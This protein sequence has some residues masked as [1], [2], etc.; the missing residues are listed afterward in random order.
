MSVFK[1][2]HAN[3]RY[4]E[5]VSPDTASKKD[6]IKAIQNKQ[7][8]EYI[9]R[10]TES[11]SMAYIHLPVDNIVKVIINKKRKEL[12]TILPWKDIYHT[13][14]NTCGFIID[15][16]PDCYLETN[17]LSTLNKVMAYNNDREEYENLSFNSLLFET[18]IH[19]AWL[20]HLG[21]EDWHN[22]EAKAS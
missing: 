7:N 4:F 15:L 2:N 5:R 19:K 13:S 11:R 21:L 3:Q 6:I 12:V 9:K 17:S 10:L 20:I 8:I 16:Y 1:N 14:I 22:E 18:A